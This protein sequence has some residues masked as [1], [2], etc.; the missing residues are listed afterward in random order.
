MQMKQQSPICEHCGYNEYIENLPHQ[1]PLGT[2]LMDQYVV[3]KALGQGS[4]GITYIGLDKNL[5]APVAIKEFYPRGIVNR[6][7]EETLDVRCT[8]PKDKSLF[9]QGR[10]AF[11]QEARELGKLVDVP[12]VVHVYNFFEE[13]NT[14]YII[15]DYVKGIS[16]KAYVNIRGGAL[17]VKDT[18]RIMQSVMEG[19]EKV[20]EAGLIHRGVRPDN[21]MIQF[22]GTAKLLD[23]GRNLQEN[24]S[25]EDASELAMKR[26]FCPEDG[27]QADG[28]QGPWTDVYGLCATMYYCM[29]GQV[30]SDAATQREQKDMPD[31]SKIPDLNPDQKNALE[32]G[33]TLDAGDRIRSVS[34]FQKALAGQLVMQTKKDKDSPKKPETEKKNKK[35]L[36]IILGAVAAV[37]VI[38]V[39]VLGLGGQKSEEPVQLVTETTVVTQPA[40][41]VPVVT[42]PQWETGKIRANYGEAVYT[43]LDAGTRVNVVGR[44]EEYY[45]VEHEDLDLLVHQ[46][47]L[48]LDSEAPYEVWDGYS[49]NNIQ[50]YDNGMLKDEPIATLRKNT[51]VRVREGK[52]GWLRI[53]WNDSEGYVAIDSISQ[54]YVQSRANSGADLVLMGNYYGPEQD[55]GFEGGAGEILADGTEGYITLLMRDDEVKVTEYND[56]TAMIWL[57]EALFA[58]VPRWL[59]WVQD[60]DDFTPWVGYSKWD[61]VIYGEC[62]MRNTLEILHTNVEVTVIDELPACYVVEYGGKTG[63][64][65]KD[66]V[67]ETRIRSSSSGGGDAVYGGG[68]GGGGGVIW[69]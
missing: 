67:S 10:D 30:P 13:N 46:D 47:Y 23:F 11:M 66:K 25:E 57:E 62:Q 44:C 50:V 38:A 42:E 54:W 52:G 37:A 5:D 15:M 29:T 31:W 3:G 28:K 16:L 27:Y 48:R 58:E 69:N 56:D 43:W 8:D 55:D 17:P 21:I 39:A 2:E 32:K 9:R 14:S 41:T 26:C 19:L 34:D 20:H 64:M 59:V 53:E 65:I 36:P 4:S 24:V 33:M 1:L 68:G 61:G 12:Q 18:M 6:V 7:C 49:K 51:E 60:D 35:M 45:V 63:Y 22:D 40:E